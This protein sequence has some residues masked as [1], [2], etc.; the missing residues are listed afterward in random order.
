M[1]HILIVWFQLY[2]LTAI[3]QQRETKFSFHI[4]AT[5][6]EKAL[7]LVQQQTKIVISYEY[8]RIQGI[9]VKARTYKAATV[10]TIIGNLLEGTTLIFNRRGDQIIIGPA[11]G[12]KHSLSGYSEGAV[13]DAVLGYPIERLTVAF[14]TFSLLFRRSVFGNLKAAVF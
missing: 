7:K 12:I 1:R 11:A 13:F 3:S 5:T 2:G 6:L 4:P 10:E 8:T 14:S 9:T